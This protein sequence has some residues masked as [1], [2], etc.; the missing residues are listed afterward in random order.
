MVKSENALSVGGLMFERTLNRCQILVNLPR[1]K[2]NLY[3]HYIRIV[4]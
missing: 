1:V 3:V 4:L 2:C